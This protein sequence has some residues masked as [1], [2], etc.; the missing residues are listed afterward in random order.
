MIS[1]ISSRVGASRI[2]VI[3][4]NNGGVTPTPTPT[5]TPTVTPS[6]MP[7][8][9]IDCGLEGYAYNKT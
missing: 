7:S 3:K 2:F 1:K 5:P 8:E 6:G 4:R 9:C